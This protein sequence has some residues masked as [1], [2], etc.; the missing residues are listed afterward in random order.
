MVSATQQSLIRE[1]ASDWEDD[2][3]DDAPTLT[4]PRT[5]SRKRE[6][7]SSAKFA[8]ERRFS[9][10]TATSTASRGP[11]RRLRKKAV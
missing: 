2:R 3:L 8:T 5:A 6:Q 4:S 9:R 10:R 11:R 7:S 1:F